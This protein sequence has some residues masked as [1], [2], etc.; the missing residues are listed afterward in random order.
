MTDDL[1]NKNAGMERVSDRFLSED[2]ARE[3]ARVVDAR[4]CKYTQRVESDGV[5]QGTLA[6]LQ[7]SAAPDQDEAY[8]RMESTS[9][10][11]P[12]NNAVGETKSGKLHTHNQISTMIGTSNETNT[13][14]SSSSY[15]ASINEFNEGLSES[16][17][18]SI[19]DNN[20]YPP[21]KEGGHQ[22]HACLDR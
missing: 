19:P 22:R 2:G 3:Q 6:S 18:M 10:N 17:D 15:P 20:P 9:A 4:Q 1:K 11:A 14:S 21:T 7:G 5:S 12:F 13:T 16:T 8:R